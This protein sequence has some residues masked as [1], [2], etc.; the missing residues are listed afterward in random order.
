M[1]GVLGGPTQVPQNMREVR[2]IPDQTGVADMVQ[3]MFPLL[4]QRERTKVRTV[5]FMQLDEAD[6][7]KDSPGLQ[8]MHDETGPNY[9]STPQC[10]QFI[11]G[12]TDATCINCGFAREDCDHHVHK[13]YF[14]EPRY[15]Q[16]NG[17][18]K[19]CRH[20]GRWYEVKC[21]DCEHFTCRKRKLYN[22]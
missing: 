13:L 4:H 6:Q 7:I 16:S 18:N 21:R 1:Q 3:D 17:Y 2:H 8:A 11:L 20:S 14:I 12:R 9:P 19:M 15:I 10:G 22:R 5:S